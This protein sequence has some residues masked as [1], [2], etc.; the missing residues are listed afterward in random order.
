MTKRSRGPGKGHMRQILEVDATRML[1]S[2]ESREGSQ[3]IMVMFFSK[4][5]EIHSLCDNEL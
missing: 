1:N 3:I 5:D 4:F 2:S